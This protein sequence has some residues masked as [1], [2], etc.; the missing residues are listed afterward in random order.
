MPAE[1][2]GGVN[3]SSGRGDAESQAQQPV[4]N[5]KWEERVSLARREPRH[6]LLLAVRDLVGPLLELLAIIFGVLGDVA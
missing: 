5:A 6:L 3:I 2:G 1:S 4:C